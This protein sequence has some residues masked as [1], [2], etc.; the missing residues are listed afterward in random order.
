L[1]FSVV[2]FQGERIPTRVRTET[3]IE[4]T[5][6]ARLLARVGTFEMRVWN[7]PPGGGDS[8]PLYFMVRFR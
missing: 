5:I 2:R 8:N 7:P 4:A 3:T 1:P 6:P